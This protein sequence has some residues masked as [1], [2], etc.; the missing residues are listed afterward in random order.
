VRNGIDP[1]LEMATELGKCKDSTVLFS[2]YGHWHDSGTAPRK[3]GTM[4]KAIAVYVLLAGMTMSCQSP[5]LINED[6]NW[7]YLGQSKASHIRE[8]DVIK[9]KS[10]DKFS[11]LRIYVFDK[12]VEIKDFEVMLINGDVLKPVIDK[13]ILASD[14]SRVIELSTEGKQLEHLLIRYR[15]EGPVFTGKAHVQYGG[16]RAVD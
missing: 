14:K 9:I 3:A 10:R 11:E 5:K 15:S 1:F 8:K 7:T 13:K 4:N 16:R 12:N 2:R 6:N